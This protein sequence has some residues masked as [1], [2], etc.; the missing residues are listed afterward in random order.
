[1]K[2]SRHTFC[3]HWNHYHIADCGNHSYLGDFTAGDLH[4]V[5]YM[6]GP[7]TEQEDTQKYG[8]RE[9]SRTHQ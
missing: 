4:A 6:F 8:E 1:M 9:L 7:A 5:P 3:I 2:N